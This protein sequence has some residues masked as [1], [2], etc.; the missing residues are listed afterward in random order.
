VHR[1]RTPQR[2]T[3]FPDGTRPTAGQATTEY[4][5]AIALI[6]AI[7][8]LAA[9]AVG[10]PDL[11]KLVVA[12]MRLALCIVG[13]DICDAR[14]AAA[15]GLAPCPLA[16]DITGHE[17]TAT[18]YSIELGHQL[19]LTVT[20]NSDGTV[21]VVRSAT[22]IAGVGTGA[23][24]ELSA[25]PVAFKLGVSGSL[26][27]RVRGAV[28]WHFRD[29]AAA[30]RFLEHAKVN[31]V[32]W[33]A[34]PPAWHSVENAREILAAGSVAAGG[35]GSKERGELVGL[36]ASGQGAIGARITTGRPRLITIYGRV[37]T[38]GPELSFPLIPSKGFGKH[39][40]LVELTLG[41]DGARELAFRHAAAGESDSKLTES[42]H[43]LDLRD[44]ANRAVAAPLLS[45]RL[46]WG[47]RERATIAAVAR[48]IR[49]HGTIE[50]T[51]SSV[52]DDTKGLSGSVKG[53]W[54]F[55]GSIKRIKVHRELV[56]AS[57]RVG[58]LDRERYDCVR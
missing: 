39:E 34:F 52:Q 38:D 45:V 2:D 40:W 27:G 50:R 17:A 53:G 8:V 43:R 30:D 1:P 47:S 3:V 42:V 36:A 57:A 55:G 7:L 23:G 37:S 11:G 41:P 33:N 49:S 5:A 14:S 10:A 31:S 46:P 44:P 54:K 35:A 22:G 4:I 13:A 21:T 15:A 29:Q 16:T 51:V 9:P 6:A 12:K 56:S 32:R 24:P 25:G 19:M 20:P 26:T 48:R 28:A 58:G 18:A